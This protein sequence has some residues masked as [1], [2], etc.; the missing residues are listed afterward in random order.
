MKGK[1]DKAQVDDL[2]LSLDLGPTTRAEELTPQQLIELSDNIS[3][4]FR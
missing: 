1:L 3:D 4:R 2:M